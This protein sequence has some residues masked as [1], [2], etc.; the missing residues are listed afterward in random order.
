MDGLKKAYYRTYQQVFDIG[1]RCLHWRKPIVISGAG[2]IRQVPD[3]LSKSGV[4][5]V[6]VVTGSHVVKS[7]GPKLFAALEDA[8][9]PYEV[10]SEV[11][12]NPSVN[13]VEK[14]RTQYLEAGC[15]GFV[16]LGGG[17][18]MD[19]TKGAAA[20]VACDEQNIKTESEVQDF[21]REQGLTIYEADVA[22]FADHV[23]E[24]YL[25]DPISDTWDKDLLAQIQAMA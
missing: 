9:M 18:P 13:T 6:M 4:T 22:A 8:G 17:S 3:V 2:C 15:S 14:I 12:A 25:A 7:L 19:A 24:T 1:M 16:A 20:R 11:E 10:F 5:K 21:L 23:L